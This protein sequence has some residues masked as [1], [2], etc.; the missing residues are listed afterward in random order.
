MKIHMVKKGDSL[1]KIAEKYKVD[2]QKLIEANPQIANPE[3][4]QV[5]D[6]VKIPS[7]PTKPQ[8]PVPEHAVKHIVQQGD[9]LWKLSK[10]WGIPLKEIIEAN[11]QLKNPSVLMTGEI[12][13]IPKK[14]QNTGHPG[15]TGGSGSTEGS[16]TGTG[17][18]GSIPGKKNTAPLPPAAPAPAP[19]QVETPPQPE[20]EE[21]EIVI[22]LPEVKLE[23]QM[24]LEPEPAP[25]PQVQPLP[26]VQPEVPQYQ[27]P[28]IELPKIELP[29]IEL[30]PMQLP[31]IPAAPPQ[32]Q[33]YVPV[34]K[35]E[36]CPPPY[37]T[38]SH[39]E[40]NVQI[41]QVSEGCEESLPMIQPCPPYAPFPSPAS[42]GGAHAYG[43][44]QHHVL[45]PWQEQEPLSGGHFGKPDHDPC[46]QET[47]VPYGAFAAPGSWGEGPSDPYPE[48]EI[49]EGVPYQFQEGANIAQHQSG[50]LPSQPWY[51]T[52]QGLHGVGTGA[53]EVNL[54]TPYTTGLPHSYAHGESSNVPQQPC[55]VP[56]YAEQAYSA[57]QSFTQAPY[58]QVQAEQPFSAPQSFTQAPY[59]QVQADQSFSAPQSF[60]QAPY[61]QVPVEQ[62]FSAPQSFAQAPYGQVQA[63]QPFSA[64][65]L[66]T[67][68]P[69]GQVP[70]EQPFSAPQSFTQAPYGQMQA[71]QPFSPSQS[72]TQAP[73]GQVPVEQPFSAS[74]S[75]TQAPYGQ[76]QA[77][78]AYSAPQ[79]FAQAPYGQVQAEQP[80]SAPQSFAQAP[81]GQ[82]PVEQP[83][84][85][86]QTFAQ[87]PYGQ[88]QAEQ[89]Y[90][91]TPYG[92]PH[93]EQPP[94]LPQ[95]FIQ[96]PFTQQPFPHTVGKKD[97][98]C[99]CGGAK[100]AQAWQ[101]N[102]PFPVHQPGPGFQQ[103]STQQLTPFTTYGQPDWQSICPPAAPGP[104]GMMQPQD[105]VHPYAPY[106]QPAYPVMMDREGEEAADRLSS[107]AEAGEGAENAE[108]RLHLIENEGEGVEAEASGSA[109]KN[110]RIK[111]SKKAKPARTTMRAVVR[112]SVKKADKVETGINLPWMN[113]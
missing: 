1:Y 48:V 102:A 12:V 113:V 7:V 18:G 61:G 44:G 11:A 69:Y 55:A 60:T 110:A 108:A 2:L 34:E 26:P 46:C 30:P 87:A 56:Q 64:P 51:G 22:P 24:E 98:G 89:P 5:G 88:G 17:G 41:Q 15:Q 80:F 23:V 95:P 71:E 105:A 27:L 43:H 14:G 103:V 104:Y 84:S 28:Q 99:G 92:Q 100:K 70:V 42:V 67:Q 6:K 40:Q 37:V 79:S 21:A 32:Q 45:H 96:A 25:Q 97:C 10:A 59:G 62:P 65:Q 72:F 94:S 19:E 35:E 93:A 13:Y 101:G 54:S 66:F 63:E 109:G 75:F 58:S 49:P 76:M 31:Q 36:P 82:V 52:Q 33:I 112:K 107:L 39:Y 73:Y 74:Q 53:P 85:A 50:G 20:K 77:E 83:F 68:A 81:Y 9:T 29:K 3:V 38:Y 4:I 91:P 86:P 57:P 111:G 47:A 8:H 78:Q 16:H 90:A 106:P